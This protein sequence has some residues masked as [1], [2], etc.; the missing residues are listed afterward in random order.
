MS[1]RKKIERVLIAN[2]GEIARRLIAACRTL[3]IRPFAIASDPD[4]DAD[5]HRE[6]HGV[7][8]LAGATAAET[9]L[10]QELVL[11]AA[12]QVGADA[13]HP[14]YGFLS[15]NADFAEACAA[16][17][18]I[19]VGPSPHAMRSMGSKIEA[20]RIAR[21]A[22]VPTV[23]G[24]SGAGVKDSALAAAA[25]EIGYPVLIKASAGGGG[26]GMRLVREPSAFLDGLAAARA[27]ASSAFGDDTVL[28]ES[29]SRPHG[30]SRSRY[31]VMLT[32]T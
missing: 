24:V 17:G 19:F 28:L 23:P 12:Q 7:V 9:Y 21:E 4:A 3:G 25:A 31:W 15:E 20:V 18:T 30:T 26:R 29:T 8:R 1:G 22:G 5:W 32:A 27:E 16:A 10:D 2:R 6:A 14:G 13:V 11:G